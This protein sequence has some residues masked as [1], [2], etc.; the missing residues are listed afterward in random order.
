MHIIQGLACN[1][2]PSLQ[3]ILLGTQLPY[4][5]MKDRDGQVLLYVSIIAITC[6]KPGHLAEE[7]LDKYSELSCPVPR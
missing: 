3:M 5:N 6:Q 7:S 4:Y 2:P 1:G